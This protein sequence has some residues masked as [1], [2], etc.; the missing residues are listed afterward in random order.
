M[1]EHLSSNLPQL[2]FFIYVSLN[3]YLTNNNNSN[4]INS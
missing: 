3:L 2:L 1:S 4:N